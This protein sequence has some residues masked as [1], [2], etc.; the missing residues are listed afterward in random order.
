MILTPEGAIASLFPPKKRCRPREQLTRV[1]FYFRHHPAGL[2]PRPRSIAEAGVELLRLA[3]RPLHG[4]LEQVG[5]LP[6][7]HWVG[8]ETDGVAESFPLQQT[9]QLG[10]G[11]RGIAPEILT[12]SD[13]TLIYN[14]VLYRKPPE[15]VK[16]CS[17]TGVLS[18]PVRDVSIP[19]A[20]DHGQQQ[21][22]PELGAGVIATTEHDALQVAELIEQKLRMVAHAGEVAVVGGPLLVAVGLARRAVHIQDELGERAMAVGLVDPLPGE[23]DQVEGIIFAL[24]HWHPRS[25]RQ[26]VV[27]NAGF[28]GE[29]AQTPCR[30]NRV[31]WEIRVKLATDEHR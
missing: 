26:E 25:F 14:G 17:G 4:T 31:I 1:P 3:R 23:I 6:L 2:V 7:Q 22:S 16:L 30:T 27:G 11:K 21:P 12:G 18:E 15:N 28:S 29:N 13:K 24:T 19:I 10:Q 9:Q 20:F 5:D 8:L